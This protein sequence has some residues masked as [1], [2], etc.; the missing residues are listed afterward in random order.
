MT[1]GAT[2]RRAILAA[3]WWFAVACG[4]ST[5]PTLP[6]VPTP[7][8]I[9]TPL[10]FA[11]NGRLIDAISG[12]GVAGVLIAGTGPGGGPSDAGGGFTLTFNVPL[13][14]LAQEAR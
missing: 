10:T 8:P 11:T 4:P 1:T 9:P 2:I 12:V 5:T 3:V 6:T 7:I 13:D 14:S